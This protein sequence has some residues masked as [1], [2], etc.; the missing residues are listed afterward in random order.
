MHH[1]NLCL[2][3]ASHNL[4][5]PLIFFFVKPQM[6]ASNCGFFVVA[7]HIFTLV[8]CLRCLLTFLVLPKTHLKKSKKG[9]AI[10]RNTH[11]LE[12]DI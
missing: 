11:H 2:T 9:Q 4:I 7:G 10:A 3:G 8:F 1:A 6:Q 12:E 5:R